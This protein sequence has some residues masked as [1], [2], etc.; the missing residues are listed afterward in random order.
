VRSTSGGDGRFYQK[1]GKK[2]SLSSNNCYERNTHDSDIESCD[3]ATTAKVARLQMVVFMTLLEMSTTA[4]LA[5]ARQFRHELDS[6]CVEVEQV[7]VGVALKQSP[8]LAVQT[9]RE[10]DLSFA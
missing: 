4:C 10:A 5:T 6:C 1:R 7:E 3:A 8:Q 9:P 2:K